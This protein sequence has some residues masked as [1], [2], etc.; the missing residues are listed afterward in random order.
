MPENEVHTQKRLQLK[1]IITNDEPAILW[2]A[3]GLPLPV[4]EGRDCPVPLC[5]VW[6]HLQHWV[7]LLVAST[8]EG[9]KTIK[10]YIHKNVECVQRG[11][12]RW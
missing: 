3:L 5:A 1:V 6:H 9:Y 10:L 4:G 12:Q 7:Q 11:L 8:E 2:G